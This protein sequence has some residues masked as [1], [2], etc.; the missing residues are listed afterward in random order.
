ML[1]VAVCEAQ[2]AQ[3]RS[4]P[5]EVARNLMQHQ[6]AAAAVA[7]NRVFLQEVAH[8]VEVAAPTAL[9]L[10]RVREFQVKV[11]RV[12]LQTTHVAQVVAAVDPPVQ[13][14]QQ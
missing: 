12:A 10:L 3:P 9:A 14:A 6:S 2:Q 11:S 7:D 8:P 5:T 1:V 4:A 13:V